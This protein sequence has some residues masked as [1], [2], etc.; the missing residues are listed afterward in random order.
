MQKKFKEKYNNSC[1]R[2]FELLKLLYDNNAEYK[3][4]MKIFSDEHN[5]DK[6]KR[7][8]VLNKYLNTL[9]VYGIKVVKVKNKFVMQNGAFSLNFDINDVKSVSLLSKFAE[10]MPEGKNKTNLE[11][12]LNSIESRFDA[13][14]NLLFSNYSTDTDFSFYYSNLREQ[15]EKCE[16]ACQDTFKINLKYK[17]DNEQTKNIICTPKQVIYNNKT[18]YLRIYNDAERT[19]KDIPIYNIINVKQLPSKINPIEM[20]TTVVFRIKGR[21]ANAYTLKENEYIREILPDGSKIIVNKNEPFDT[22][23]KR[24]LRYD[25]DCIIESPKVLRE[26]M[27]KIINDTLNNY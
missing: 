7:N 23:L 13:E 9:K 21:L 16:E 2:I 1:V 24:L 27:I 15:I 18:A 25:Y 14:T 19:Y 17:I 4:V 8:V 22:L 20:G 12:F 3:A 26:E 11:K 10:A 5:D 6:K